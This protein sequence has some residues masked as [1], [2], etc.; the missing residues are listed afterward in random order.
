MRGQGKIFHGRSTGRYDA[1]RIS[2][3]KSFIVEVHSV[4]NG[5]W[6]AEWSS[7]GTPIE[8]LEWQDNDWV[9]ALLIDG[10]QCHVVFLQ[11]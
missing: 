7:G 4:S 3:Q 6:Y 10:S 8:T 11:P 1:V 5:S 2:P 9:D